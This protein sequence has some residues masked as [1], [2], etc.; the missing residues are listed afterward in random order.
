MADKKDLPLKCAVVTSES[1][2]TLGAD[3]RSNNK[4]V[5]QLENTA[6]ESVQFS[7]L[8]ARG[9][10]TLKYSLGKEAKDL[11]ADVEESIQVK[12]TPQAADWQPAQPQ[13]NSGE[14]IATSPLP[15][16]A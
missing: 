9:T 16:E 2:V 12:I 11:V 6:A 8:G 5:V 15:N 1:N 10:L 3:Q 13:R 14:T 4:I 7:G